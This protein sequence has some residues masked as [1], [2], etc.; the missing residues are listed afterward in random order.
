MLAVKKWQLAF[1]V[2][3]DL[4]QDENVNLAEWL[5][6][7]AGEALANMVDQQGFAGSSGLTLNGAVVNGPFL[8]L[9]GLKTSTTIAESGQVSYLYYQGNSST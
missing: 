1:A 4:L 7:I 3:N 5:L 6:A 8:G 2:G 9:L